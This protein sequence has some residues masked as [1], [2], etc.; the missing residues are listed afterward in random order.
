MTF[1]RKGREKGKAMEIS[2]IPLSGTM[3]QVENPAVE[4]NREEPVNAFREADDNDESYARDYIRDEEERIGARLD[5]YI[6][7]KADESWSDGLQD[8]ANEPEDLSHEGMFPEIQPL[9]L[10]VSDQGEDDS[11][12]VVLRPDTI[13][14]QSDDFTDFELKEKQ[15]RAG[16]E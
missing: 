13:E 12:D 10:D 9:H 4:P 14:Q 6:S 2:G 3:S 7:N 8:E 5:G 1:K 15:A 16:D 11:M